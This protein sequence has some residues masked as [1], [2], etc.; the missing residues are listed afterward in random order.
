VA[1]YGTGRRVKPA[2]GFELRA[3]YFMRISGLV[4]VLLALGH[5]FV[6]HILNS[7]DTINYEFVVNRWTEPGFGYFW[8][9]WDLLMINLAV[10]HGFN[11][12]RQI[13]DEY[14]I[15]ARSRVLAH[16]LI[17]V[18]A[19][20]LITMGTYAILMFQPDSQYLS[21]W[22]E[23]QGIVRAQPPAAQVPAAVVR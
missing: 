15:R 6:M 20:F 9:I 1:A 23:G 12:L 18:V 21:R 17:G 4:L 11:G 2:G 13:L 5:L 14:L 8:R 22:R 10:L 16:T 7:V 3:W 19:T